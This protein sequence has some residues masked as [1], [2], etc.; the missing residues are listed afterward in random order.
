MAEVFQFA[1]LEQSANPIPIDRREFYSDSPLINVANVL[2]SIVDPSL[3][4]KRFDILHYAFAD[5]SARNVQTLLTSPAVNQRYAI[6]GSLG[7]K[8]FRDYSSGQ[9]EYVDILADGTSVTYLPIHEWLDGWSHLEHF[10]SVAPNVQLRTNLAKAMRCKAWITNLQSVLRHGDKNRLLVDD[11]GAWDGLVSQLSMP[12]CGWPDSCKLASTIDASNKYR[13]YREIANKR[14]PNASLCNVIP[15]TSLPSRPRFRRAFII[16]NNSEVMEHV[17]RLTQSH[18]ESVYVVDHT[19]S[20]KHGVLFVRSHNNPNEQFQ[21]MDWGELGLGDMFTIDLDLGVMPRKFGLRT[22]GLRLAYQISTRAPLATRIIVTAE[23]EMA[24]GMTIC[25]NH[26]VLEKPFSPA[27]FDAAVSAAA[28]EKVVWIC[29]NDVRSNW[30]KLADNCTSFDDILSRTETSLAREGVTIVWAASTNSSLIS[31]AS[32][33]ILDMIPHM[34]TVEGMPIEPLDQ[35]LFAYQQVCSKNPSAHVIFV[36]PGCDVFRLPNGLTQRLTKC[37]RPFHDRVIE[38]PIPIGSASK[39]S[40][41]SVLIETISSREHFDV[42]YRVV[43]P[44]AALIVPSALDVLNDSEATVSN[45]SMRE[46]ICYAPIALLASERLGFGFAVSAFAEVPSLH[47]FLEGHLNQIAGY[48]KLWSRYTASFNGKTVKDL[49]TGFF[50]FVEGNSICRDYPT[51]ESWLRT[52]LNGEQVVGRASSSMSLRHLTVELNSLFGGES[53]IEF[54]SRGGWYD[55]SSVLVE[56]SSLL[57]EFCG[58]RSSL[59]REAI[60][61]TIGEYLKQVGMEDVVLVTEEPISGFLL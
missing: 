59:A 26:V 41:E 11:S 28:I 25:N 39:S 40:L 12:Q 53:R 13:S 38:K 60:K 27:E 46:L 57:V 55:A 16:E 48:G 24:H 42:K 32:I 10:L 54:A 19:N 21:P 35:L 49:V 36:V 14:C 29:P 8:E 20:I 31:D 22:D 50:T 58:R 1:V 51:I 37:I 56:D 52:V 44:L 43:I 15:N 5:I 34:T 17:A 9:L 45:S 7:C 30:E 18:A 33:V 47:S 23:P 3:Q 6:L 4:L 2:L 61:S